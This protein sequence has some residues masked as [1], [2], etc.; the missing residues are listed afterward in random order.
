VVGG[1]TKRLRWEI[2]TL[3][4]QLKD[5]RE[6]QARALTQMLE[7]EALQLE[8]HLESM[9]E[10]LEPL[11][12]MPAAKLTA[13]IRDWYR[14]RVGEAE[15]ESRPERRMHGIRKAAKLA[16]YMADGGVA[17]GLA[18]KF[19]AVQEAGGRWHDSLTLWAAARERLGKRSELAAV[20]EEREAAARLAFAKA[21]KT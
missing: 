1:A 6:V 8:P 20:L 17:A 7:R 5:E 10:E 19:E 15:S 14:T 21:A 18:K 13:F 2:E 12:G 9:M 4:G 3:P 16:R 11:A